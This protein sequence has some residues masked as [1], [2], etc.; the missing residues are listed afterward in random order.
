M[1]GFQRILGFYVLLIGLD[2]VVTIKPFI[3]GYGFLV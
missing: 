2:T 1:I 3:S